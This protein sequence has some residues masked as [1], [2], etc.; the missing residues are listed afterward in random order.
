MRSYRLGRRQEAVERTRSAILS[1][2][3]D[4]LAST[5]SGELSTGAVARL[6]GVSR[7]TVY[8]HFGSKAGMLSEL[9]AGA[10]RQNPSLPTSAPGD[11][12]EQLRLRITESC[13]RWASDPAL[14]R[15]LPGDAELELDTQANDHLLVERLA[16]SDQ[17]RPGCSIKEAEDV[18]GVLTSFPVFDRLHR[19]GRRSSA[20]VTEILMRIATAILA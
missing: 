18:I 7:I 4:L 2:A 12:R 11:P 17:I 16:A 14:F 3:R 1:A 6:A 10:W 5:D 15:R 20:A 13:R 8:N 9:A 19:E